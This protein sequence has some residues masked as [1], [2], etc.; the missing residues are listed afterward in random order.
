[1]N[2]AERLRR[3]AEAKGQR[4]IVAGPCCGL[5]P[6]EGQRQLQP[7]I[8]LGQ[9]IVRAIGGKAPDREAGQ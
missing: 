6:R 4:V 1:M 5:R 9:L 2:A 7:R 3:D 8:T